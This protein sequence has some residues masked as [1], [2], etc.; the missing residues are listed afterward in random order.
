MIVVKCGRSSNEWQ[1]ETQE[2]VPH[3]SLLA[4]ATAVPACSGLRRQ[5]S[6][7]GNEQPRLLGGKPISFARTR[8]FPSDANRFVTQ[9][10]DKE[11][12]M[13]AEESTRLAVA[14]GIARQCQA[15]H[16]YVDTFQETVNSY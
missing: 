6:C 3:L 5:V 13:S 15:R 2:E 7:L 9:F 8:I 11:W 12:G 1:E 16:M 10:L 14:E 4:A